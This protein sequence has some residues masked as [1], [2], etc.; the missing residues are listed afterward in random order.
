M[1]VFGLTAY[2]FPPSKSLNPKQVLR[3]RRA[4]RAKAIDQWEALG[5][6][7]MFEARRQARAGVS[8]RAARGDAGE[9]HWQVHERDDGAEHL[10][11]IH[12]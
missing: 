1:D 8:E 5:N 4:G 7:R 9:A 12:I 10:S 6:Q 11:L 2:V 3:R